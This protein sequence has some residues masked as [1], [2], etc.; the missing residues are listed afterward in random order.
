MT[1]ANGFVGSHLTETLLEYG[2]R[3]HAFVRATSSGLL[4]NIGGIKNRIVVHRGDLTDKQA[5]SMALKA[6]KADGGRP[7]IFH[8]GAQAHVGESWARPYET[9]ASNALGTMNIL[10]SIVDLDLDL[11][12]IDTAGSS[13]EYGNVLEELQ[14]FYRFDAQGGLILDERSPLNPQSVYAASKVATD[15]LT[16]SYQRAYGIPTVVTRMFN[17]YGPRQNPRFVTGTI[18]TQALSRDTIELGYVKSK[19]DFCFVRD[20]VQ[21]HIHA[22]LWGEPGDV[23][24]YGSGSAISIADWYEL[25]IR[26]GQ[27]EGHWKER[28]LQA[29]SGER[30]RH[31]KSEVNE[32]RVDFG[33]LRGVSGWEPRYTWEQGLRETIRWY[34]EN[35]D[36]WVGRVD[37]K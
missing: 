29:F 24:V 16:R 12:R 22:T 6:L 27:E 2:A 20:G 1:G 34:A 25:I 36:T 13:E 35:P 32:L 15:F 21:G 31:G 19:R 3:V 14:P 7:I 23:Y 8:L 17:N 37:W 18:I 26:I 33:K 4:Q 10:Q 9:L 30:T 11:Y 28:H 5:V